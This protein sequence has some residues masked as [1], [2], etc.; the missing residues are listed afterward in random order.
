[1][2]TGIFGGTF[3]PPHIGHVRAA[4]RAISEYE[5]DLLIVIPTGIPPH[6]ELPVAAPDAEMRL[7]MTENAFASVSYTEISDIEIFGTSKNYTIDT[8]NI[9]KQ[10]YPDDELFLLVGTDMYES[11]DTWK[12]NEL[13]LKI[14]KPVLLPRNIIKISSSE[15]RDMLPQR[16]GKEYLSAANYS[17][18]I[19]NKLYN[20]KPDWEWLREQAYS[21]L[22]PERIPHVAACEAAAVDLAGRWGVDIDDA[23]EAAILH[24]ITKKLD[25]NENLCIIA[26]HGISGIDF[27]KN[28]EKLFHSIT[29]AAIAKSEFAVSDTVANAISRHTTGNAGM[30]MLDKIIYIAD[31]IEATRVFPGVDKLRIKAY[32]NINEAMIIGLEM[33]ID[34][35]KSRGI[36]P[37]TSTYEALK[38]LRN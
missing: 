18:I 37:N 17:Y 23:R 21:M 8:V 26:E 32:E 25:F 2:N 34:D 29:G 9:I 12:D 11:L 31:Y 14:I 7:L 22:N 16:K 3:N 36:S 24:D 15:I 20:A 33:T 35:L 19:K 10:K 13:L 4:E 5:L 30:S 38:A 6:K 1:M 27:N 28:E